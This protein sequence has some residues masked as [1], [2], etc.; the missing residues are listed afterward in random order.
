M[1]AVTRYQCEHCGKDFKTPNK[2][3]CKKNPELKNCFSCKHWDSWYDGEQDE[4]YRTP[5]VPVCMADDPDPT[6]CDIESMKINFY[7]L[8]CSSWE[9]A[10][11]EK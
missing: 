5:R 1:K 11:K 6:E 9:F 4:Y 10:K 7:N 2:H 8:Q 3:Q